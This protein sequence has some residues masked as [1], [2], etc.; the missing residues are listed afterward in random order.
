MDCIPRA[1]SARKLCRSVTSDLPFLGHHHSIA[2]CSCRGCFLL[3]E[4]RDG[5]DRKTPTRCRS[6]LCRPGPGG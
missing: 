6:S 3:L 2:L 1:S 5:V 4:D